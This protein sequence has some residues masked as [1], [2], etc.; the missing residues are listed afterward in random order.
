MFFDILLVAVLCHKTWTKKTLRAPTTREKIFKNTPKQSKLWFIDCRFS[1]WMHTKPHKIRNILTLISQLKW[2]L[3]NSYEYELQIYNKWIINRPNGLLEKISINLIQ[4]YE[5]S[6]I[7]SSFSVL[8]SL[9]LGFDLYCASTELLCAKQQRKATL[10]TKCNQKKLLKYIQPTNNNNI[11]NY[12]M[13]VIVR[14]RPSESFLFIVCSN[15]SI[16]FFLSFGNVQSFIMHVIP[17]W[18]VFFSVCHWRW[19]WFRL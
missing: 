1:Y 5:W 3:W 4:T 2:V 12:Y 7:S 16:I 10:S 9:S 13:I 18:L 14:N 15:L 8:F 6:V 17:F 19:I 11:K